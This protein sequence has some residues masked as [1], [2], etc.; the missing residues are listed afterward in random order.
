[1]IGYTPIS[2]ENAFFACANS[3]YGF[4]SHFDELFKDCARL[5]LLKGGPGT[6]KSG[7]M[8]QVAKAATAQGH[9]VSRILCS[10]D[11]H[12]LDGILL[13]ERGIGMADGTAPHVLEATLPGAREQILDPGAFWD[14]NALYERQRE[15]K[16]L[17][18]RKKKLYSTA[19]SLIEGAK[20]VALCQ[21][22]ILSDHTDHGKTERLLKKLQAKV[23]A[24]KGACR[25]RFLSA[26]GMEGAVTLDG[27]SSSADRVYTI[28]PYMEQEHLL[29]Q[30]LLAAFLERESELI[31][32]KDPVSLLPEGIY[33]E[34]QRVLFRCGKALD[35]EKEGIIDSK[36]TVPSLSKEDKKL[37]RRLEKEKQDLVDD[38][39]LFLSGMK[40][41]HFKLEQIYGS[42][43]DFAAFEEYKERWIGQI[44]S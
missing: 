18:G 25:T 42:A 20:N 32:F 6:G 2:K 8:E 10:S 35:S 23:S 36:K 16:E 13:P 5:Y 17:N 34:E 37:L 44:L 4:V 31:L 12:S 3:G 26:I 1:M 43:M 38:G 28:L 21:Q 33:F 41:C 14:H 40:D 9:A 22:G 27:Y 7:F 24:K 39:C 19:L 30:R 29:L 15:I 11:P